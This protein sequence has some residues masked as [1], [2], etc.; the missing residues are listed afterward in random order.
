MTGTNAW[1]KKTGKIKKPVHVT[2][3]HKE[4]QDIPVKLS[5]AIESL[6]LV[7]SNDSGSEDID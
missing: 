5:K 2:P 3:V 7:V 1:R 6:P 4:A